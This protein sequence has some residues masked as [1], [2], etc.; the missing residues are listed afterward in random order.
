MECLAANDLVRHGQSP[1][2]TGQVRAA[3]F[4]AFA[5]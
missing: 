2:V 3:D 4:R 5:R 1:F